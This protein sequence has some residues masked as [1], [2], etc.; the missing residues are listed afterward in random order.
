MRQLSASLLNVILLTLLFHSAVGQESLSDIFIQLKGDSV[1]DAQ[2]L[3][4]T[5]KAEKI[6]LDSVKKAKGFAPS[7]NH[8]EIGR[9]LSDDNKVCIYSW[10]FQLSDKSYFYSSIVQ[11]KLRKGSRVEVLTIKKM[12]FL[13]QPTERIQRHNWYGALY[14]KIAHVKYRR[15]SY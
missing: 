6:L 13:P 7:F 15:D 4:L 10:A 2:K 3:I 9:V 12:P 1:E 14:Y 11:T 5:K 8:P